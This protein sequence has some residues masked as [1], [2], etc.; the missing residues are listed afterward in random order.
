MGV[1]ALTRD[2]SVAGHEGG[3]HLEIHVEALER[4][5]EL[6]IRAQS[7]VA[8]HPMS[9]VLDTSFADLDALRPTPPRPTP[10]RDARRSGPARCRTP[11][12]TSIAVVGAST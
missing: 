11:R 7:I 8:S 6:G 1:V 5:R 2:E 3:T 9:I 12:R 4:L 10:T